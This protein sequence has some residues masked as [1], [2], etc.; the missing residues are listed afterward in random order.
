[1][2]R[3]LF[4]NLSVVVPVGCDDHAWQ[5]L[6]QDLKALGD[7][8]EI[9]LAACQEQPAA[10]QL[11]D[12]VQWLQ[13]PQGRARQLN[14]GARQAGRK[15]IWFLHA[16][17]RLTVDVKE[18]VH[19]YLDAG[20]PVLG[21]FRLLFAGDGPRQTRLNAW[22]ANLRS[23]FFGLPF[24]DQGFL[25]DRMVFNHMQGFDENIAL[26]EDLDFVVRLKATGTP[27][28]E[29]PAELITSA[30]RYRQHGWLAT[31]L[32]HVRLTWQLTRQARR[33]LAAV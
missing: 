17:S 31:T 14:A 1:M 20:V 24:G 5:D 12:N 28:Q 23:R 25:V 21:Y 16:D 18:A 22:A 32:R 10:I 11:P 6:L 7:Y 3:K 27:L 19:N 30:R 33:R 15:V 13:A 2:N 8:P 9:I 4:D 26:G 29:L